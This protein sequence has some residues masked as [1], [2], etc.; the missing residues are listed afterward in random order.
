LN[1]ETG[2]ILK[3]NEAFALGR[4]PSFRKVLL[5]TK[6]TF[7]YFLKVYSLKLY[8]IDDAKSIGS[9]IIRSKVVNYFNL[10]FLMVFSIL[11]KEFYNLFDV[12]L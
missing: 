3:I 5:I 10:N 2:D 12:F 7:A 1:Q 4:S 9:F 11:I 8:V 6:K